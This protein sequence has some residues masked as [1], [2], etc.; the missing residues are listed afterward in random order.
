MADRQEFSLLENTANWAQAC[1]EKGGFFRPEVEE[2]DEEA[3][4]NSQALSEGWDLFDVEGRIQLQR[5]DDPASDEGLGYHDPKFASDADALIYVAVRAHGGSIYHRDA[6]EHI[7][8]LA[9]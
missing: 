1:V 4:N 3:F 6:I 8:S 9:Q 5:I 7:G 2:S